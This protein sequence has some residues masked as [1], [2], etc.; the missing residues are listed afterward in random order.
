MA[1]VSVR[2]SVYGSWRKGGDLLKQMMGD[3]FI[4]PR[5]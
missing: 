4:A 5:P 2:V 1:V 3:V